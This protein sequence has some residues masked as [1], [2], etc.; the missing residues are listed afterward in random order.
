[1][2]LVYTVLGHC[3]KIDLMLAALASTTTKTELTTSIDNLIKLSK[4]DKPLTDREKAHVDA[5]LRLARGDLDGA[6]QIWEKILLTYPTDLH[7]LKTCYD[8]YFNRGQFRQLRDTVARVLPFWQSSDIPL[9]GYSC[10][11]N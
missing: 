1:M 10:S 5:T 7:A 4:S 3:L 2:F 8:I 6:C 11:I 9:K